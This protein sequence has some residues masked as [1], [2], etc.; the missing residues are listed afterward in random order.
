MET[1]E[2]LYSQARACAAGLRMHHLDGDAARLENALRGSTSGEVLTDLAYWLA[3]IL[4]AND[5]LPS[6]LRVR[7]EGVRGTVDRILRDAGQF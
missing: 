7:L 5:S 3:E 4:E 1:M 2:D 6:K